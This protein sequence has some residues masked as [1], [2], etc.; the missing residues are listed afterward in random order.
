[1]ISLPRSTIALLVCFALTTQTIFAGIGNKSTQYVGGT[2]T[3]VAEGKEGKLDLSDPKVAR[4]VIDKKHAPI[5]IPYDKVSSLEYG[6]KAGR[7]VGA[8]I[9]L[10]AATLGLAALP[11]LL[12]KK[13]KHYLTVGYEDAAGSQ[14][15][16]RSATR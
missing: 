2:W 16:C 9:G 3:N 10:G 4:F 1:M 11:V 8:T 5:E 13:R 7:R 12:S 14:A 6:Q 15:R